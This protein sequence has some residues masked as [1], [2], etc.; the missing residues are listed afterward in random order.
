[1]R[2]PDRCWTLFSEFFGNEISTPLHVDGLK[3][4][5]GRLVFELKE[6]HLYAVGSVM[7]GTD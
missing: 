7:I 1:M 4:T 2:Y 5:A 3:G 6:A